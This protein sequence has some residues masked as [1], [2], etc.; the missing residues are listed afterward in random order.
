MTPIAADPI[1]AYNVVWTTPRRD[2]SESM[3]CG[4]GDIGLNVWVLSQTDYSVWKAWFLFVIPF[5]YQFTFSLDLNSQLFLGWQEFEV[6]CGK[7]LFAFLQHG[8][9]GD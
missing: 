3:P 7:E 2:A 8:V 9:A 6:F 1:N 5:F 4:G